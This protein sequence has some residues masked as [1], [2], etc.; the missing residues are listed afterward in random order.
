M[1]RIRKESF[2]HLSDGR[3]AHLFTI[4]NARGAGASFT[5]YGAAVVSVLVPDRSGRLEDVVLGYDSAPEYEMHDRCA[6]ATCGRY[7]GRLGGG[8]FVLNG[9][10][11][12]TAKNEEHRH[13]LH[14]GF[15]GF[16]RK[17]WEAEIEEDRVC[18]RYVSGDGEEGFPGTLS[19][20]VIYGFSDDNELSVCYRGRSDRDTVVNLTNHIYFNLRGHGSGDIKNHQVKL[21]SD[22]YAP[23]NGTPRPDGQ[24]L[25]VENTDMDLREWTAIGSRMNGAF[26]QI[27]MLHGFNHD[28]ILRRHERGCLEPG[29]AVREAESGRI[30][31]VYTT[32][33]V[34]HFFTA[35]NLSRRTGKKKAVYEVHGGFCLEPGFLSDSM[36]F[37]HFPSPVLRAGETYC[38]KTSFRFGVYEEPD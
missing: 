19:M 29:G 25:S 20:E 8:G 32:K 9:R 24:I 13:T 2:G 38:H 37:L 18:F 6:G 27:R 14:G 21:Y 10:R 17:L 3:E 34:I 1:E 11:Y 30:M 33:P 12:E 23:C 36:S 22:Y 26:K 4:T 35:N 16:D 7:A 15:S 31:E 5:N 28:Y